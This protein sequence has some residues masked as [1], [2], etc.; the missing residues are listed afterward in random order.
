MKY[1]KQTTLNVNDMKMLYAWNNPRE[2][3][4]TILV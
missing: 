4:E 2:K 1:A 3:G